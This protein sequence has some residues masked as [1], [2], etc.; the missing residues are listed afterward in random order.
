MRHPPG[1]ILC[2]LLSLLVSACCASRDPIRT[3]S[4]ELLCPRHRVAM[5]MRTVYRQEEVGGCVFRSRD[6]EGLRR[7]NPYAN[8]VDFASPVRTKEY[9]RPITFA[10]CSVCQANVD[11]WEARHCR[12][13]P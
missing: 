12:Q 7:C 11:A 1:A 9:Q 13:P 2:V 3:A 10:H 4:G 6:Y 8:R 5:T